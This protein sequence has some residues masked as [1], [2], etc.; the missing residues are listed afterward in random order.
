MNGF[1]NIEVAELKKLLARGDAVLVDVRTDQEV[2]RGLIAGALHMPLHAVP[3][4]RAELPVDGP[5]VIYCQSGMR[6]AQACA[7][8]A[9]QGYRNLYN[10]SGGILSWARAGEM[11]TDLEA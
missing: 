5:T 2:A 9:A 1:L 6:S 8:L 3:V 11:L 7:W 4:R 10:L